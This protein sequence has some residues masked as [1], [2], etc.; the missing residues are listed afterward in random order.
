M[1][2]AEQLQILQKYIE[3]NKW[4]GNQRLINA[5][6]EKLLALHNSGADFGPKIGTTE[7]WDAAADAN[8][9]TVRQEKEED[10]VYKLRQLQALVNSNE[11]KGNPRMIDFICNQYLLLSK[12]VPERRL[13][14][15]GSVDFWNAAI[16]DEVEDVE[17]QSDAEMQSQEPEPADAAASEE[18]PTEAEMQSQEQEPADAAASEEQEEEFEVGVDIQERT[19]EEF[20][21]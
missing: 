9:R 15:F 6:S 11:W 19:D 13:G 8:A 20:R 7:F 16:P 17:I 21:K 3:S 12:D 1:T 4:K 14:G 2:K 18:V 5:I 10:A